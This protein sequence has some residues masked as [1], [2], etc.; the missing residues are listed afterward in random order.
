MQVIYNVF[1]QGPQ[2]E[3][4]PAALRHDVGVIVRVPL[5]EGGLTGRIREDT[6]FPPGD[7]REEYFVGDR[8]AQTWERVS[9]IASDLGIGPEELPAI[10]LRFCVSAPAVSTVIAGMRTS[11]NVRRNLAAVAEGPLGEPTLEL[12]RRHAWQRPADW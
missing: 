4:F 7:F 9:A 10:A 2:E 1:E 12:L 3:L 8:R 5:D 11:E 6:T